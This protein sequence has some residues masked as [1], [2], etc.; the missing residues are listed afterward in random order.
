VSDLLKGVV[1]LA[2]AAMVITV[3]VIGPKKVWCQVQGKQWG[4]EQ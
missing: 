4:P 3:L 1:I 2:V